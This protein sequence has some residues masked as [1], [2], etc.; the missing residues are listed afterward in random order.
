MAK[1]QSHTKWSVKRTGIQKQLYEIYKSS[2]KELGYRNEDLQAIHNVH[3]IAG[4]RGLPWVERMRRISAYTDTHTI[5]KEAQPYLLQSLNASFEYITAAPQRKRRQLA[6]EESKI[7]GI[8]KIISATQLSSEALV[9]LD[10]I[11]EKV[12]PQAK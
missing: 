12:S 8:S 3:E 7:R 2:I 6:L 11:K 5:S 10:A 4:N 1:S 9:A